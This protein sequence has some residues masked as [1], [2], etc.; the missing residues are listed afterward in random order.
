MDPS[1]LE[2]AGWLYGGSQGIM[3]GSLVTHMGLPGVPLLYSACE[4]RRTAIPD[5]KG[6]TSLK[7]EDLGHTTR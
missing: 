3:C 4:K 2:E 5:R 7:N 1:V 6:L